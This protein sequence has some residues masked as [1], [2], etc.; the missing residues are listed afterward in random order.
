[1]QDKKVEKLKNDHLS[2]PWFDDASEN[3]K[4]RVRKFGHDLK[5]ELRKNLHIEK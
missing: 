5:K 4:N 2:S 1:M 3:A